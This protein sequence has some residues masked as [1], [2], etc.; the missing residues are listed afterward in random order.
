VA[1]WFA[2]GEDPA[3]KAVPATP[4][5]TPPT[6]LPPERLVGAGARKPTS[7]TPPTEGPDGSWG[8]GVGRTSTGEGEGT[9]GTVG[10]AGADGRLTSGTA[11]ADGTFTSGTGSR[12]STARAAPADSDPHARETRNPTAKRPILVPTV[13]PLDLD[14]GQVCPN[15][16]ISTPI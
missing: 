9:L 10:T 8:D 6:G 15:Q 2:P 3:E 14:P 13:F 12:G 5:T 4:D 16:A 1:P 11:G 7:G